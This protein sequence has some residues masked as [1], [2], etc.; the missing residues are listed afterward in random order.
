PRIL[1]KTYHDFLEAIRNHSEAL[2]GGL[3]ESYPESAG[4][5][6]RT[7]INMVSA[8][9]GLLCL[10]EIA[11]DILMWSHYTRSHSG[12]VIGLKTSHEF[13]LNPPLLDVVYNRERVLMGQ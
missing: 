10:S 7:H 2:T 12:L 5:F 11:D 9:F 4:E 13:F 8:E 3:I 1:T 6:R